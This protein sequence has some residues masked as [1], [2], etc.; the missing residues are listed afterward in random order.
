MLRLTR[1]QR[2]SALHLR[3]FNEISSHD[4]M[5]LLTGTGQGCWASLSTIAEAVGAH[6]TSVSTAISE[7]AKL[8]YLQITP[9]ETDRRKRV[10]RVI[11]QEAQA[12]DHFS[13]EKPSPA[14]SIGNSEM[15]DLA[16]H[17]PG[18]NRS[19]KIVC[20]EQARSPQKTAEICPQYIP[21]S[22][23]RYL[24]KP[25]KIFRKSEEK[26]SPE[27]ARLASRQAL[28]GVANIDVAGNLAMFE[29]EIVSNPER[30]DLARWREWLEQTAEE[31]D[32]SE[33]ATAR[34]AERLLGR[35]EAHLEMLAPRS[36]LA[37]VQ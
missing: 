30:L 11:Y 10:Y 2:L 12:A 31:P 5:S 1:D 16:G 14:Q 15:N 20:L 19:A 8:G 33:P 17:L 37:R 18:D 21:L 27:G 36:S 28:R 4:R 7:L 34:R 23:E 32:D 26:Y 13:V 25:D 35:L 9:M 22:G 24:A 29:R 6:I 3:V